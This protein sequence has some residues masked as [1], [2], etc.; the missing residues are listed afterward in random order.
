[1]E[2]YILW[3]ATNEDDSLAL[4]VTRVN[5]QRIGKGTPEFV[6]ALLAELS[7]DAEPKEWSIASHFLTDYLTDDPDSDS[8]EDSWSETWD[9][10]IPVKVSGAELP[11]SNDLRRTASY[12]ETAEDDEL[13]FPVPLVLFAEFESREKLE[14]AQSDLQKLLAGS[15]A[16]VAGSSALRAAIDAAP[17][18]QRAG[19]SAITRGVLLQISLGTVGEDFA[20]SNQPLIDALKAWTAA[21]GGATTWDERHT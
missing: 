19:M 5:L 20:E 16:S 6:R 14:T 1:M 3:G 13:S 17:Q 9:F 7:I 15:A 11:E 21:R 4:L 18:S 10:R 12:D 8:W 2:N